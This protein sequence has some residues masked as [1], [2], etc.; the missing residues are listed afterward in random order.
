M[1][2]IKSVMTAQKTDTVN[3]NNRKQNRPYRP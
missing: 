2:Y 3:T 1:K